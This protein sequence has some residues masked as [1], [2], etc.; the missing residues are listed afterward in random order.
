[1]QTLESVSN[2]TLFP[3]DD[4]G[5]E[6]KIFR[7]EYVQAVGQTYY[8]LVRFYH[9]G[10]TYNPI[11]EDI[12]SMPNVAD[13][14]INTIPN[15]TNGIVDCPVFFFVFNVD[16]YYHFLY[17]TLPYLISYQY[18]KTIEPE[19]KLLINFA[20]PQQTKLNQ[21]VLEFLELL[22][23]TEKDL[24]YIDGHTLYTTVYIS[25]SYT[26]DGKSNL[27]P[28][29]EVYALYEELSAKVPVD[30]GSPKKIYIS[31]RSREHGQYDNIGT[32]YTSKRKLVN[33]DELV[34]LLER[35]GYVEIF[36]ELLTTRDKIALFKNCTHVIGP[37]GGGLCNVL[38]SKP[39]VKLIPIVSPFFLDINKRFCFSFA[40]TDV[41][42]FK[43]TKCVEN[44]KYKKYMRVSIPDLNIT[45][46]IEDI[47][48]DYLCVIYSDDVVSGWNAQTKYKNIWIRSSE[49][50]IIDNGLNSAWV[51]DMDM[52]R[53]LLYAQ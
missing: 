7:L 15:Y 31:R 34:S 53:D 6:I 37:I 9:N 3:A 23:I 5:R 22:D 40:K 39:G 20:N 49:V 45:G 19:L 14:T 51:M 44:S 8:P 25:S 17:D 28:R 10:K 48:G 12:M 29:K 16:N 32:N 50:D 21:F 46:E 11:R 36:T 27:P 18:L 42:Y 41:C 43:Y 13:K 35:Q 1:M 4:N 47:N 52:F 26:H 2:F 38:F 30:T 24:I 33:E